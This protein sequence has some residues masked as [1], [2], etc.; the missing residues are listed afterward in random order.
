L[1]INA[2]HHAALGTGEQ[3]T[4]AICKG[5]LA[6]VQTLAAGLVTLQASS[7][8]IRLIYTFERVFRLMCL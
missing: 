1:Q 2:A 8:N 7:V 6:V 4:A 5:S 3:T